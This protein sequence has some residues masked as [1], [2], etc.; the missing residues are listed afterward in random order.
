MSLVSAETLAERSEKYAFSVEDVPFHLGV[1]RAK[2]AFPEH[3]APL[4]YTPAYRE[5]LSDEDRLVYNQVYA[6]AIN[7][8]FL[9]LEEEFLLPVLRGLERHGGRK[10]LPRELGA[11][12]DTF[13]EE[14]EKHSEMFRKLNVLSDPERY[15]GSTFSFMRVPRQLRPVLD[16]MAH[17][18]TFAMAWVWMGVLFEEKTVD[19]FQQYKVHA[20][21]A[22]DKPLDPL[23]EAVHKY[24]ALDEVRHVQID[25][26]LVLALYDKAP[27]AVRYANAAFMAAFLR[28]FT[29]PKRSQMRVLAELC[30]R[31]PHLAQHEERFRREVLERDNLRAM[32]RALYGRRSLPKTFEMFDER[33]EMI[34]VKPA[35]PGYDRRPAKAS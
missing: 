23:Y 21:R 26:H 13:A 35:L 16:V 4:F 9:F 32:H 34:V 22:P 18:P 12:L 17:R 14:E 33:P 31:R 28:A 7:E 15:A 8:L 5:L 1:D 19:Y 29:T 3:H 20:R 11:L 2:W 25:Q 27:R 10:H 24:H 6:C 30:R